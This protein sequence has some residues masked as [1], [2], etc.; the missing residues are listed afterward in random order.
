MIFTSSGTE[1]NNQVLKSLLYDKIV[2]KKSVHILISAIEHSSI[3]DTVKVLQDYGID[4]DLIPVDEQ[5][6]VN[7]SEY[8][9]LFRGILN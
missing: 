9:A 4:Y 6:K 1:S 3:F 5:G 2:L 7:V 8:Q